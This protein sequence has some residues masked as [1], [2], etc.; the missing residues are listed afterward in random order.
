MRGE[1]LKMNELTLNK[2]LYNLK[3]KC[4]ETRITLILN[5]V[6]HLKKA[7]LQE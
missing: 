2:Y 7:N 6:P 5:V 4:L 3:V 1:V